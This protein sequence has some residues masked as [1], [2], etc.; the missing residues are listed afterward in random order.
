MRVALRIICRLLPLLA[1]VGVNGCCSSGL[2]GLAYQTAYS[3]VG[4][5]IK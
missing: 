2:E 1:L 4:A 3:A 5:Q